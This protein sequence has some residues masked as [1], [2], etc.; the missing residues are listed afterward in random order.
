[1]AFQRL[2]VTNCLAAF[3]F[4]LAGDGI[5]SRFP[6]TV[7]ISEHSDNGT[8]CSESESAAS[9]EK[10][11]L[12][13]EVGAGFEIWALGLTFD[14]TGTQIVSDVPTIGGVAV[15][16]GI[17]EGNSGTTDKLGAETKGFGA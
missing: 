9:L 2:C 4:S 8:S 12:A 10:V 7:D 14:L 11:A 6:S 16:A 3:G 5:L 15:G 1:M 13:V 17:R